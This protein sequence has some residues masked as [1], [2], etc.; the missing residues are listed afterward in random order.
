[1]KL[2]VLTWLKESSINLI[3]RSIEFLFRT[4]LCLLPLG[5][6]LVLLQKRSKAS[7]INTI[8]VY[9]KEYSKWQHV[10]PGFILVAIEPD[11]L[12]N[13]LTR[14][15]NNIQ[16]WIS[17]NKY[18]IAILFMATIVALMVLSYIRGGM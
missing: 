9:T 5:I 6:Y 16:N 8:S 14:V 7:T 18:Y 1:M 4:I 13:F 17:K 11:S 3:G 2:T 10:F 15:N 12:T